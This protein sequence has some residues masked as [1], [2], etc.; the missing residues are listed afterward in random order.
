METR[1][2]LF[3]H[4]NIDSGW[5]VMDVRD[6]NH[7]WLSVLFTNTIFLYTRV[8]P[9]LLFKENRC[10]VIFGSFFRKLL[11]TETNGRARTSS[12][13]NSIHTSFFHFLRTRRKMFSPE[14][15]EKLIFVRKFFSLRLNKMFVD[16]KWIFFSFVD[17]VSVNISNEFNE[18]WRSWQSYKSSFHGSYSLPDNI[19]ES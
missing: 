7:S 11:F 13:Q 19:V 10:L 6:R 17:T 3:V 4:I 9:I 5:S 2:M 15:G 1:G 16:G 18:T 8:S 12:P 14:I